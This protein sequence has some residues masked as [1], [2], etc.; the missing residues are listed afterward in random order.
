MILILHQKLFLVVYPLLDY[1]VKL[2]FRG[3]NKEVR[4]KWVSSQLL[5]RL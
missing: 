5:M 1:F 2:L 4:K 3:Q